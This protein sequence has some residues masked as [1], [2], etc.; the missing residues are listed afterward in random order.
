MPHD[1]ALVLTLEARKHLME[2]ILVDP[3]SVVDLLHLLALLRLGYNLNILHNIRR[4]LVDFNRSH[5][6]SLGEIVLPDSV[7]LVTSLVLLTVIDEPSSFNTILGKTL[8]LVMKALP[9]SYHKILSFQTLLGQI[10]IR[11]DHKAAKTCYEVKQ[12]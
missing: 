7:G 6:S 5:T 10:D 4:V 8:I 2:R 12:H 9:S 3:G 11:G 1:D